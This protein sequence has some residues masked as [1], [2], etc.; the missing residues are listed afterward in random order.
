MMTPNNIWPYGLA[1]AAGAIGALVIALGGEKMALLDRPNARSSHRQ[2]VPRG[3]GIG[4][5]GAFVIGAVRH[6]APAGFWIPALVLALIS[7]WGDRVDISLWLRLA[8]QFFLTFCFLFFVVVYHFYYSGCAW[9]LGISVFYLFFI[10]ATANF[11]NFMDGINGIAG[12]TGLTAFGLLGAYGLAT[13]KDGA[14]I[15][16]SF[17]L[18]LACAGFLPFNL[19]RARVFMGDVGSVFLGFAFAGLVAMWSNSVAE[20]VLLTSFLFLFY[21]DELVT[22]VERLRDGQSPLKAHRRHLYQVL[23]NEAGLPHWRVSVGYG[24]AQLL[25][26]LAVWG[27]GGHGLVARLVFLVLLLAAFV[28]FNNRIK[29]RYQ[30]ARS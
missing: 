6:D 5:L 14:G 29:R 27:I 28:W 4:L 1:L 15:G 8:A 2:P 22:L 24:L 19:P 17:F 12:I 25:I 21:A 3:G 11:Y 26:G 7:F 20:F 10:V 30:T 13:G 18:A 23:A 9:G 16:I